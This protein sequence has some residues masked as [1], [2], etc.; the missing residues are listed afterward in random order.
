MRLILPTFLISFLITNLCLA[1]TT[2][3]AIGQW[4]SHLP[5]SSGTYVTQSDDEIFY[6]TSQAVLKIDK[7]DFAIE[8]LTKVEGLSN[9]GVSLVKYNRLS[10]VLM[11][12]FDGGVID[13]VRPNGIESILNI[14][15]S[16]IIIGEK[17]VTDIFFANDSIAYLS[18]NFGISKFNL[19]TGLFPQTTKTPVLV[20][21]VVFQDNYLYAATEEGIYRADILNNINIDDFNNWD[22]LDVENN[23]PAVYS[24]NA[25]GIFNERVYM[26][27]NDTLFYFQDETINFVHSE[28]NL[29]IQYISAE[30][31][32]LIVGFGNPDNCAF[33][34]SKVFT[35]NQ[36]NVPTLIPAPCVDC[37]F[38]AVEDE[39]GRI[40]FADKQREF[41][42]WIPGSE[43]CKQ[44]GVN[45]P[46]SSNIREISIQNN[47][48]WIASGGVSSSISNLDRNDGFFSLIDGDWRVYNRFNTSIMSDLRDFMNVRVHPESGKVYA[49]SFWDGLVE[50]DGQN[51]LIFDDSNS[52][53]NNAVQDFNRT[54][55]SGLAF[56]SDNNL[57][58]TNNTAARPLSV[59]KNDGSWQSFTPG[60]GCTSETGF[61]DIAIDAFGYKWI[62]LANSTSQGIL[63]FDEGDID[64]PND[65]K[66]KL[67]ST[68]SSSLPSN[69]VTAIEVDLD[70]SV[71]VG[72][73]QGPIVFECDVINSNCP[74]SLRIGELDEFGAYLLEEEAIQSI[75]ID[76]ANRKWFGTTNGIFV[77]SPSAE[78]QEAN[79]NVENSPLFDNNI[80][81]IAI[82][83]QNGEVYIGTAK[84][85]Q[86]YRSD[87]TIGGVVNSSEVLVFP[88]PVRPEYS[89][90]IAIKGLAQD[91]D[92]KITDINGQLVYET[93]ALGG[94]AI[95][96][97]R[98]YNGRKANTGVYLV[99]STSKNTQT[100]DAIVTK[101]LFV[102]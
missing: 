77:M 39:Q 10:D 20:N 83:H 34:S 26:A 75:A 80:I 35:I 95:W 102:N 58:I 86:T 43:E 88:N 62:N 19:T 27:I 53:L 61:L 9:V 42:Y 25:M 29:S 71:W 41:K 32:S 50:F 2:D 38:Y 76:G 16:S 79:F 52:T 30:G 7:T 82:N 67:L 14:P 47:Q 65:N 57:W 18:G 98:D 73:E 56:D 11:V 1:Q 48:V 37:P 66:C 81:D 64:D 94:Q 6:A 49:S 15:E 4:K 31:S 87:A 99:F 74:G 97:G 90:P 44:I 70:G 17:I 92:I 63:V 72:T 46:F 13:L 8:R 101:I 51:F 60:S 69:R 89:G 22:Y 12:V 93:K 5:F 84:G 100:P 54:R 3:L 21:S 24:S 68:S 59:L 55:V 78:E 91:A 96:D 23:F 28:E 85:L 40:W 33:Q 45:S 36:D